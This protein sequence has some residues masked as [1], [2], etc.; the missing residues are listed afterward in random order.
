MNLNQV[1]LPSTNIR[2]SIEFYRALGF[3][4]IVDSVEYARFECPDG[5]AT[6]SVHK[7][8]RAAS[9][10][11]VVYFE[12]EALDEWVARLQQDGVVFEQKPTDQSWRWREARLRDPD[13]NTLCLFFGGSDR[14][15]PPWRVQ[16]PVQ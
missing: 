4:L 3:T 5:D 10:G 15:Y 16:E 7:V 2:R 13:G 1:T 12:H 8:D 9:D 11:V 14:K 6:F